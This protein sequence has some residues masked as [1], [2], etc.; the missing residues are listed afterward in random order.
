MRS[1]AGRRPAPSIA[2]RMCPAWWKASGLMSASVLAAPRVCAGRRQRRCAAGCSAPGTARQSVQRRGRRCAQDAAKRV[3]AR[4]AR[5][6]PRAPR[7]R[8][9]SPR[10]RTRRGPAGGQTRS[11]SRPGTAA[12]P[13]GPGTPRASGSGAWRAARAR[14]R[15][16]GG[17]TGCDSSAGRSAASRWHHKSGGRC[18]CARSHRRRRAAHARGCRT[19]SSRQT[20]RPR[21]WR[22][23]R[24]AGRSTARLV[25]RWCVR[26]R[27]VR[28]LGVRR[29]ARLS[30]L[31]TAAP[32]RR[33]GGG[34]ARLTR[35]RAMSRRTPGV[36][37]APA[38]AFSRVDWQ[39]D[40]PRLKHGF[41]KACGG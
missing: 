11:R 33:Y 14:A 16:R 4:A 21:P 9:A 13:P 8:G 3:R 17:A 28:G 39:R 5:T 40:L 36:R 22:G 26:A 6:S 18:A 7:R 10:R 32:G 30:P 19:C 25:F 1:A 35:G 23:S 24:R 12:R 27:G 31:R 2:D 38:P 34:A 20:S 41:V 37:G 29:S 15:R